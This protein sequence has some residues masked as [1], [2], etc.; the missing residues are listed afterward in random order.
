MYVPTCYVP[1]ALFLVQYR[2]QR[3]LAL[4]MGRGDHNHE[5]NAC[6]HISAAGKLKG[7]VP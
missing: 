2:Y 4:F 3:V 1:N 5:V 6:L 7:Q